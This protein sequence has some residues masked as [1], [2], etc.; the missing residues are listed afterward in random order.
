MLRW[1]RPPEAAQLTAAE[2]RR[3]RSAIQMQQL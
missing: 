2:R 1:L 3:L